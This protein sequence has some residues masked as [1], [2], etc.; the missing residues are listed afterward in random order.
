MRGL[1]G[2][3]DGCRRPRLSLGVQPALDQN[4]WKVSSA[5]LSSAQFG[6]GAAMDH[7]HA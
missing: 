6:V 2:G 7:S 3:T 5:H 4:S 1:P